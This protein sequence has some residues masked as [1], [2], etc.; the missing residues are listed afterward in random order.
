MKIL[1]RI[2]RYSYNDHILR[3]TMFLTVLNIAGSFLNYLVH[4]I[5]TRSLTVAEYGEFQAIIS[6]AMLSAL[7]LSTIGLSAAKET[8]DLRR[9]GDADQIRHFKKTILKKMALYGTCIYLIFVP[10]NFWIADFFKIE[11]VWWLFLINATMI[12]TPM[13]AVNK[14]VLQGNKSFISFSLSKFGSFF[15][16]FILVFF[17]VYL[18]T[19]G[20]L[21]AVIAV[22]LTPLIMLFV[23]FYQVHKALPPQPD[24]HIEPKADY[25]L[26]FI[27][28]YS[29]VVLVYNIAMSLLFNTDILAAKYFLTPQETGFYASIMVIGRIIMYIGGALPAVMFPNLVENA[30]DYRKHLR[31]FLKSFLFYLLITVPVMLVFV[32]FPEFVV[33][34][35]IGPKYLEVAYLLPYF[36]IPMFLYALVD[37]M[38]YY[39][40]A[41]ESRKFIVFLFLGFITEITLILWLP[42]TMLHIVLALSVGLSVS[43]IGLSIFFAQKYLQVIKAPLRSNYE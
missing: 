39:C 35:F 32:F 29:A 34:L 20:L 5:L 31:I 37:L 21:G 2:L 7:P 24:T 23:T 33:N 30:K 6:I 36:T 15:F 38:N 19:A 14:G 12:Y 11:N 27:W 4:P 26:G 1:I 18:L 41:L 42:K 3:N 13:V 40:L 9:K 43:L 28:K 25:H 22:V 10:L 16:K 8:S 17:L